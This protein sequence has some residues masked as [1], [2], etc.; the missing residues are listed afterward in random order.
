VQIKKGFISNAVPASGA[1]ATTTAEKI[2]S[3]IFQK[4]QDVQDVLHSMPENMEVWYTEYNL[5]G[6]TA[7][8]IHRWIHGICAA[9]ITLTYLE[10]E[11]TALVSFYDMIGKSGYEAIYYDRNWGGNNKTGLAQY[12][13]T[14][15]G[16]A[17]RLLASTLSGMTSAQ[18]MTFSPNPLLQQDMASSTSLQG[19][20]FTDGTH[21]QA[22]ILNRSANSFAWK[23]DSL[24]STGT[25]FQ[26]MT[27]D[28]F[29]LIT[30]PDSFVMNSGTLQ[31]SLVLPPFS[32]TQLKAS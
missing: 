31:G 3:G 28:P 7:N 9:S 1:D 20:V 26:Q 11:H 6:S 16:Y 27:S 5:N 15:V 12:S 10:D 17:M 23:G 19:W 32:V 14:A 22:F 24:F 2:V 4:W 25:N 21:K 8:I 13:L 18:K 29:K 30:G